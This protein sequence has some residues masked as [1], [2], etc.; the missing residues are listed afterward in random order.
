MRFGFAEYETLDVVVTLLA[1]PLLAYCLARLR[2]EYSLYALMLFAL[3]LFSPSTIH[4]LMSMP[5][6]VVVLFPLAIGA[7]LLLR[8]STLFAVWMT[9]SVVLLAVLTIQFAT[10]YWVA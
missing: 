3:P 1:L 4:P 8:R 9:V 6:F 2:V 7:A 5:R 10:W